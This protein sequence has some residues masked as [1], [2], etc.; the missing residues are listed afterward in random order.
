MRVLHAVSLGPFD[1]LGLPGPCNV[2]VQQCESLASAGHEVEIV[3]T[4]EGG[5]LERQDTI[6]G[7]RIRSFR[8]RRIVSRSLASVVSW[9]FVKYVLSAANR[10]SA[11]L[12]LH[13]SRDGIFLPL[14]M[15]C[16]SKYV[17]VAQTHGQV[18]GRTRVHRLVDRMI[19]GPLLRRCDHTIALQR[20]EAL[21]LIGIGVPQEKIVVVGNRTT[22]QPDVRHRA[23]SSPPVVCFVAHLRP[24]KRVDVAVDASILLDSAG[25]RH[26]LIVAGARGGGE[27]RLLDA[28]AQF[29]HV[30]YWGSVDHDTVRSLLS[31]AD[32]FVFPADDEPFG[33]SLIEALA[34]GTPAVCGPGIHAARGLAEEDGIVLAGTNSPEA[35]AEGLRLVISDGNAWKRFSQGARLCAETEF[36]KARYCEALTPLYATGDK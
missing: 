33:M 13:C 6:Q 14:L 26:R 7:V 12:H 8:R 29:E 9:R 20:V 25:V 11:V 35:I 4:H 3:T 23:L 1:G 15:L 19:T 5:P 30:E 16:S 27:R 28:C 10:D 22:V 31:S 17:R 36:D 21:R 32:A 24:R 34:E 2:A 18:E